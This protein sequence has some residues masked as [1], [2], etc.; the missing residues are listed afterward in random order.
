MTTNN[1][2]PG[3]GMGAPAR[4]SDAAVQ[5]IEGESYARAWLQRMHSGTAEPGELTVI[6]AFLQGEMLHGA[7]RLIEKALEGRRHA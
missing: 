2:A 7:C 3:A 6:L 5:A 1:N 4:L